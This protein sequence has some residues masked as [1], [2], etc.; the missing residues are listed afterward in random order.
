MRPDPR[1][2]IPDLH[3]ADRRLIMT[4]SRLEGQ[5]ATVS[6]CDII[7]RG[8]CNRTSFRGD[9]GLGQ[10]FVPEV[11]CGITDCLGQ[12]TGKNE[13][14]SFPN[15]VIQTSGLILGGLQLI[16]TATADA[17]LKITCRFGGFIGGVNR[18][19]REAIGFDGTVGHETERLSS[20]VLADL[21]LPL[22]NLCNS[23]DHHACQGSGPAWPLVPRER[24]EEIEF[25]VELL[26]RFMEYTPPLDGDRQDPAF[27]PRLVAR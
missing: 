26:K 22:L 25:R 18:V 8:F 27:V 23:T 17:E 7:G 9:T 19:F 24:R 16:A 10:V 2:A 3:D 15:L 14:L 13:V 5:R 21:V 4:L 6:S 1:P 12:L 20:L 11:S